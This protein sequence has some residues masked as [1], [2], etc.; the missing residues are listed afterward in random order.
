MEDLFGFE[1]K[2]CEY[3][4]SSSLLWTFFIDRIQCQDKFNKWI[5]FYQELIKWWCPEILSE[6][7]NFKICPDNRTTDLFHVMI[8]KFLLYF[9]LLICMQS[10]PRQLKKT[11]GIYSKTSN[12]FIR[13]F[14]VVESDTDFKRN[15][16]ANVTLALIRHRTLIHI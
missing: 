7:K 13:F 5:I 11:A 3:I 1:Y 15:L 16:M 2:L 8:L 9:Y 6:Y 4:Y 12:L 14:S 10:N